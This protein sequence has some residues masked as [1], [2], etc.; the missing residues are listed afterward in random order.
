M[1]WGC[2]EDGRQP[3]F[4]P[5]HAIFEDIGKVTGALNV[6]LEQFPE[7]EKS[8]M[9]T[10]SA[11]INISLICG[12]EE[13]FAR[14]SVPVKGK[15][16]PQK[17][18]T[19]E[20]TQMLHAKYMSRNQRSLGEN[21]LNATQ[22][23]CPKH[24]R[25]ACPR[26]VLHLRGFF[27]KLQLCDRLRWTSL[28]SPRGILFSLSEKMWC[29]HWF[30]MKAMMVSLNGVT[31]NIY[32]EKNQPLRAGFLFKILAEVYRKLWMIYSPL[33]PN[34]GT[35]GLMTLDVLGKPV[36]REMV[37]CKEWCTES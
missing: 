7:A 26:L 37:Y 8:S 16:L 21:F 18:L 1:L 29:L 34:V 36:P 4:A 17:K 23:I 10:A 13:Q 9:V 14:K 15:D 12:N 32:W 5:I 27:H 6:N 35:A 28:C 11:A 2:S 30:K 22:G 25:R 3:I 33:R 20:A 31:H 24:K 19:H